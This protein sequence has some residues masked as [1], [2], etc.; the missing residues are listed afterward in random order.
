[1]VQS[2][3]IEVRSE[4]LPGP[5]FRCPRRNLTNFTVTQG[6]GCPFLSRPQTPPPPGAAGMQREQFRDT[7]DACARYSAVGGAAAAAG[8]LPGRS[9]WGSP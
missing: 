6:T 3:Y 2:T 8:I 1:M 7:S 5:M 4:E 9:L